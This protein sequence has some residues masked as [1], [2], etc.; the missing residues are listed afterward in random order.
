MVLK[1]VMILVFSCLHLFAKVNDDYPL[2]NKFGFDLEN[3]EVSQQIKNAS[4]AVASIGYD[5]GNFTVQVSQ[6]FLN[7]E[8][9]LSD[10]RVDVM[11]NII[12]SEIGGLLKDNDG[13]SYIEI[14]KVREDIFYYLK[15]YNIALSNLQW[16]G[17]KVISGLKTLEEI[18]NEL[19]LNRLTPGFS[20]CTGWMVS[21]N[22]AFTN[23]HCIPTQEK[24][25]ILSFRFDEE[26]DHTLEKVKNLDSYP[27]KKLLISDKELDLSIVLLEGT[28]GKK[29]GKLELNESTPNVK[30]FENSGLNFWPFESYQEIPAD[31]LIVIGH[32][33]IP[34]NQFKT[35]PSDTLKKVTIPCEATSGIDKWVHPR[36]SKEIGASDIDFDI[37]FGQNKL[38]SK[39]NTT[40]SISLNCP[41]LGGNSGSP[42]LNSNLEVVGLLYAGDERWVQSQEIQPFSQMIPIAKIFEKYRTDLAK[43]GIISK[44]LNN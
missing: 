30:R 29:H 33:S 22:I 37:L 20:H 5:S 35:N 27:C 36:E 9:L 12:L 15:K 3:S 2:Y 4:H 11:K 14:N 1:I 17:A 26:L 19:N 16:N 7:R 44:N 34:I 28:P 31:K 10:G 6:E 40:W 18:N 8:V 39:I 21:D 43:W 13:N 25:S 38:I 32:P 24:C 23:N 42:V 41:V